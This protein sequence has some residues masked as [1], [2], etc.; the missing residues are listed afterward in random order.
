M[1]IK[2]VLKNIRKKGIRGT[3]EIR[4]QRKTAKENEVAIRQT[5]DRLLAENRDDKLF[6]QVSDYYEGIYIPN[7]YRDL[8]YIDVDHSKVVL[9]AGFGHDGRISDTLNKVNDIK[10]VTAEYYELD[11]DVYLSEAY[12]SRVNDAVISAA[13]A[14]VVV[15]CGDAYFADG[16]SFR[17][18]TTVI[19][20]VYRETHSGSDAELIADLIDTDTQ[21]G[22][23]SKA[24]TAFPGGMQ[25]DDFLDSE[26]KKYLPKKLIR[27][28]KKYY[29][30]KYLPVVYEHFSKEPVEE[31]KV[32]ILQQRSNLNSS[33]KSMYHYLRDDPYFNVI[34]HELK[35]RQVSMLRFYKNAEM[36]IADFA[37]A[38]AVIT[39]EQSEMLGSLSIRLE[40]LYIQLWHGLP[41]KKLRYSLAGIKGYKSVRAFEEYPE[42]NYDIVTIAAP[43]WR[44]V[45]EEFMGLEKDTPVIQSLGIPRTDQF[46]DKEYIDRCYE[47]LHSRIPASTEKKVILYAPTYRGL[48]PNRVA[49]D[50][51]DIGMF[52]E[53]LSD[54]YILIIKHH[55]TLSTWPEIPQQYRDSFAYDMTKGKGMDINELMTVSDI[56]ITDYS[57]LVFDFA[58]YE[59]P[60]VFFAYDED[61]Y[62]DERGFYY[63]VGELGAGPVCRTNE[64]VVEYIV[65]IDSRF[66]IN[67]MKRFRERFIRD[68][69]GHATERIIK[70][71]KEKK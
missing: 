21:A 25:K 64:E 17:D 63:T 24:V 29:I 38:R 10:G 18:G 7:L 22:M 23:V 66:D 16:I 61:E 53:K 32:I 20:A 65:N 35:R 46:Y 26:H 55:Q 31:N 8:S 12:S 42:S 39:H 19:D 62:C 2:A 45:F 14:G 6:S 56:C 49:P 4:S 47:K 11:S 36:F 41:L 58:I 67:D 68:C 34:F 27:Q 15:L 54:G 59:R 1:D 71:I 5:L 44:P 28:L 9:L 48:E 3:L 69:D 40:S 50:E 60:I 30:K 37:T 52:A 13:G 33:C 70:I 51:I 43:E 57:S